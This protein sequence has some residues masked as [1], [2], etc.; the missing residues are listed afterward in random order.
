MELLVVCMKKNLTLILQFKFTLYF[1]YHVKKSVFD[2]Q[3]CKGNPLQE[4][5]NQYII[6][7]FLW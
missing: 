3:P 5:M 6:C 7:V 1:L 4:N 2:K